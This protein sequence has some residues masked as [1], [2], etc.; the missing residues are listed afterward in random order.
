MGA[1]IANN[2]EFCIKVGIMCFLILVSSYM[3]ITSCI[4]RHY[5]TASRFHPITAMLS[6]FAALQSLI[7]GDLGSGFFLLPLLLHD[8]SFLFNICISSAFCSK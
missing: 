6:L 5:Y 8:E 7:V 1:G 2:N 4:S 3:S